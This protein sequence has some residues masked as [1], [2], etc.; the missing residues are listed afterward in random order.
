MKKMIALLTAAVML[1]VF[2]VGC[3]NND[4]T[5][6]P[7]PSA[8]AS[9]SASASESASASA[10][11]AEE[12]ELHILAAASLTDAMGELKTIYEE[13]YPNVT[14]TFTFDSSGTLQTQ[15]EEG[16]PADVFVSAAEKQ[17]NALEEADL[18]DTATRVD[19]LENKLVLI[20]PENST[21]DIKDFEDAATN[22]DVKII[23]VG[24]DTVPVGQ[25]TQ[26]VFEKMGLWDQVSAKANLGDNVRA[27][28]SWVESGD[29]DCGFVYATDAAVSDG[30]KVICEAPTEYAEAITYPAATVAASEHAEAAKAFVDF[31]QTSDAA[32]VFEAAGFTMAK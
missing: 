11:N 23:G 30:V 10:E 18:I 19:L 15:I 6:S 29:V 9:A 32:A 24:N 20:V 21:L 12:V 7:S 16:A 22:E 28:L 5:T 17:M 4:S 3:T 26:A 25:Y 1:L 27:V 31:L 14:L 2:A 8:S 13:K